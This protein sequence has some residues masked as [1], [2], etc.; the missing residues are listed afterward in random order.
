M[1]GGSKLGIRKNFS[2]RL[3]GHWNGLP[4]ELLESSSLEVLKTREDV[5]LKDMDLERSQAWTD[6]WNQGSQWSFHPASLITHNML[7]WHFQLSFVFKAH[8]NNYS[9]CLLQPFE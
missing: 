9:Y 8:R 2:K 6:G 7:N 5:A 1:P 3:V 4:L